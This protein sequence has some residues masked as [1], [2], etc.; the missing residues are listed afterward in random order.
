MLTKPD[1]SITMLLFQNCNHMLFITSI[2][3]I[4]IS[5]IFNVVKIYVI[6]LI[7]IM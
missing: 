2:I 5:I 1:F 3:C 6:A 7:L 4:I